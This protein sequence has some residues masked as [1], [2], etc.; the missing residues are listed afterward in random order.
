MKKFLLLLTSTALLISLYPTT[1]ADYTVLPG[2]PY[3]RQYNMELEPGTQKTAT[4]IVKNLDTEDLTVELYGA[5]ATQSA[6][7]T[8]ALTTDTTEQKHIGTWIKF[9]DPSFLVPAREEI[10]IP[11]TVNIPTRVTPGSYAGGIAIVKSGPNSALDESTGRSAVSITSRFIVKIFVKIPGEVNHS[12]SWDNFTFNYPNDVSHSRFGF[13]IT[14]K[15]NTILLAEPKIEITGF[16]P[17]KDPI[18]E[19]PT[20]TISQNSG[21]QHIEARWK[22]RPLIGFYT[23][24]GTV[25]FSEFDI[26][27]NKKINTETQERE[28]M[29]NLTPWYIIVILAVVFVLLVTLPLV[30]YIRKKKFIAR[31]SIYKVRE[32]DTII[33]IAKAKKADWKKIAKANKL[34]APY[35]LKPDKKILIPPNKN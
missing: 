14:N 1:S 32:G 19:M 25:T 8:F 24:K 15:G 18:I 34:K 31:C 23:A 27:N 26:A 9:E 2:P 10:Q 30:L 29:I 5:D 28:I 7:G 16:P 35:T 6:Q 3:E 20:A 33:S 17:L 13:D 12:Y 22:D 11:F 21:Q 4:I